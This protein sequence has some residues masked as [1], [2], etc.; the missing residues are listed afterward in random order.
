MKL[1][2]GFFFTVFFFCWWCVEPETLTAPR[3]GWYGE[4]LPYN[5]EKLSGEM[6]AGPCPRVPHPSNKNRVEYTESQKL[7]QCTTDQTIMV[8]VPEGDFLQGSR[9]SSNEDSKTERRV[10]LRG[11]YIDQF[12]VTNHPYS[13]FLRKNYFLERFW[14][15]EGLFWLRQNAKISTPV[16]FSPV[17]L[18]KPVVEMSWYE[19]EAYANSVGKKLP[20]EA[21]WEK[22]ARGPN[23]NSFP[24]GNIPNLIENCHWNLEESKRMK[25]L[26]PEEISEVRKQLLQNDADNK[27]PYL[28]IKRSSQIEERKYLAVVGSYPQ[29]ASFYKC[30]DMT[31]NVWEWVRDVYQKD[32]YKEAPLR[33]PSNQNW[34]DLRVTRGGAWNTPQE[35]MFTYYRIPRAPYKNGEDIG[36]RTVIESPIPFSVED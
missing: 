12:E 24:W 35:L 32:F 26:A 15:S 11:Y 16:Q 33:D 23:G 10:T 8:Y 25:L 21:Q 27:P 4:T 5:I 1:K 19:A 9:S 31:G 29:G 6:I 36:F 3:K 7:Y 17:D 30:M 20:T 18:Y 13:T 34:G 28:Q 2:T 14:S 22:A